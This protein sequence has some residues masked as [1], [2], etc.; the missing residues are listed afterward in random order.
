MNVYIARDGVE[1]G[2]FPRTQ[3]ESR[4]RA[5]ELQPTDYYWVEGMETWLLLGDG[6]PPA[7][8]EPAPALPAAPVLTTRSE[9]SPATDLSVAPAAGMEEPEE[10]A[11]AEEPATTS[12]A[13]ATFQLPPRRVLLL[14]AV[15]LC[16]LVMLGG[17]V[18]FFLSDRQSRIAPLRLPPAPEV[19]PIDRGVDRA[20]RDAAAADLKQRLEKLPGRAEPPQNTFFYDLRVRMSPSTD[21]V[22]RWTVVLTGMEATV[23][24]ER[25]K[26]VRQTKFTM[27]IEHRNGT[28]TFVNYEATV[29]D[30]EELQSF[31]VRHDEQ[32]EA[33]PSLASIL[34]LRIGR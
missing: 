12:P 6:L 2:E 25:D 8:P 13:A 17:L 14:V 32:S 21:P 19:T 1:L 24:P 20:D 3:L 18:L 33:P 31:E 34:G 23:D 28:W 4:L 15:P 16:A 27:R 26:T 30:L 9:T 7:E 5:G 10:V 29:T 11:S 22:S